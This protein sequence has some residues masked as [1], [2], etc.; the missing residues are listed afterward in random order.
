MRDRAA[1]G[2][3]HPEEPCNQRRL[4]EKRLRSHV[5]GG[6]CNSHSNAPAGYFLAISASS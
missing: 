3:S 1:E 4:P 6:M 5:E 2:G